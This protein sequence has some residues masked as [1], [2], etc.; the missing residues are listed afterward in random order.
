MWDGDIAEANTFN[1][2][3]TISMDSNKALSSTFCTKCA[4][5]NGDLNITPSDAQMAFDI[6]LKKISAPTWCE[7]ENADVNASGTK[8]VP[9]VTPADAQMI[10]NKYLKK[11]NVN[12]TCLGTYRTSTAATQS[13]VLSPANLAINSVFFN[14]DKDIAISIIVE[15]LSPIEAFGFDLVYPSDQFMF[16]GLERT[17]LTKEY[18]QV[19]ANVIP[20]QI[21]QDDGTVTQTESLSI[22]R[23]GGYKTSSA[24][25]ASSGTLI[26]LIF[27]FIG[28]DRDMSSISIMGICDDIQGASIIERAVEPRTD[29]TERQDVPFFRDIKPSGKR[30][31]F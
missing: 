26:T 5:V 20:Y 14:Q 19:D 29:R 30:Y 4:D 21:S 8:F 25:N 11:G 15:S 17:E 3:T 16:I 9:K 7:L 10:F 18:N 31:D 22:L 6:Y 23:V 12:P 1:A 2:K 13:P 28:E 27:R 24:V